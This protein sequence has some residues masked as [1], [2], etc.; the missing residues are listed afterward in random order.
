MI[1]LEIIIQVPVSQ[2]SAYIYYEPVRFTFLALIWLFD[3]GYG[4][5]EEEIDDTEPSSSSS[6]PGVN[7]YG[8]DLTLELV[9]DS[10]EID[11]ELGKRLN[12]MVPI[13][14]SSL[15]LPMFSEISKLYDAN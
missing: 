15:P 10:F 13:P 11:G 12:Q 7:P 6:S 5:G 14:V 9:D 2:G 1:R 3:L 8:E 4:Q